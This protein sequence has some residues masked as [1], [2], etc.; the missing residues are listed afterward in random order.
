MNKDRLERWLNNIY[1]TQDVEISCTECFDLVSH[2]IELEF[3][4]VN[5]AEAMPKVRQHLSQCRACRD[6]YKALHDLRQLDEEEQGSSGW[7]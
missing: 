6:E 5:A 3:S 4:G 2:Y 7:N 1:T